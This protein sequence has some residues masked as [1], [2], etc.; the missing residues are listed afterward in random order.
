M[1]G[2]CVSAQSVQHVRW[3]SASSR[4]SKGQRGPPTRPLGIIGEA[5]ADTDEQLADVARW[6]VDGHGDGRAEAAAAAR[7]AAAAAASAQDSGVT[8]LRANPYGWEEQIP[9]SAPL[10]MLYEAAR[11]EQRLPEDRSGAASRLRDNPT[12]IRIP[13]RDSKGRAYATGRR[14]EAVARVWVRAGDGAITVNGQTLADHFKML[15]SRQHLLEPL[16]VTQTCG[17]VDVMITVKSG[18]YRGQA[19]AIRHGLANALAR[20]DPYLKPAL[21][22]C[23]CEPNTAIE[24]LRR[25]SLKRGCNRWAAECRQR[26]D[27]VLLR[28]HSR[29]MSIAHQLHQLFSRFRS[30][31]SVGTP[32]AFAF[33]LPV[34]IAYRLLCSQTHSARPAHGRA[35]EAWPEEGTQA[36]PVDQALSTSRSSPWALWVAGFLL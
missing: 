8:S 15:S 11:E 27:S 28:F 29:T 25:C 16:V 4:K 35:Q 30:P 9:R 20:Y 26:A 22:R 14:K 7:A 32:D 24:P 1:R 19:G 31:L 36:V 23:E 33:H 3:A 18:G 2:G 5:G 12:E 6:S 17:A 21:R 10:W 34:H 13:E